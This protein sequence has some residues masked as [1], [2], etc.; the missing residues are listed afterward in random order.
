MKFAIF[1]I[2]LFFF[3]GCF[4]QV[5]TVNTKYGY[6]IGEM[7]TIKKIMLYSGLDVTVDLKLK[8]SIFFNVGVGGATLQFSFTDT[9]KASVFN[10]K[11]FL[12]IPASVKKYYHLTANS[13]A[14]I[15]FGIMNS[16]LIYDKK[17]FQNANDKNV[18]KSNV[19][20]YNLGVLANAGFR[21][22]MAQNNWY[23][24]LFLGGHQDMLLAYKKKSEKIKIKS[25]ALGISFTKIF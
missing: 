10:K 7:P 5:L 9:L 24:S 11:Y 17:E 12:M 18:I 13:A 4:A 3:T 14:F 1:V 6:A 21:T 22:K 16:F 23:I 19:F 20:G 8:E 2:T 25:T 15:E